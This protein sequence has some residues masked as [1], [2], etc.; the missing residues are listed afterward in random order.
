AEK[1]CALARG[2]GATLAARSHLADLA[3]DSTRAF[4]QRI[5]TGR[6]NDDL[7]R[8][9]LCCGHGER[10]LRPHSPALRANRDDGTSSGGK[11]LRTNPAYSRATHRGRD[12]DARFV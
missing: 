1:D 5:P 10:H 7:D 4:A 11:R 8:H 3:Y 6:A 9:S 2:N 12:E